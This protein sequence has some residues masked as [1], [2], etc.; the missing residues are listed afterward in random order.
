MTDCLF[1]QIKKVQRATFHKNC[2][3]TSTQAVPTG[4]CNPD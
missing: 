3:A 4:I 1:V 2:P